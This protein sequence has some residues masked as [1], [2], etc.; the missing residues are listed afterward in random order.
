MVATFC[1]HFVNSGMQ[2]GRHRALMSPKNVFSLRRLLLFSAP[3]RYAWLISSKSALSLTK[4]L[5]NWKLT[6]QG[7][8]RAL[9][10]EQILEPAVASSLL[11]WWWCIV[12]TRANI[13]T[14]TKVFFVLPFQR[15]IF[16]MFT[17]AF[18]YCPPSK[19]P[20][21]DWPAQEPTDPWH[22]TLFLN[23]S[24]YSCFEIVLKCVNGVTSCACRVPPEAPFGFKISGS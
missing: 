24:T 10:T 5:K 6:L 18:T 19:Q 22:G 11:A 23:T 16:I 21:L 1:R 8:E 20:K 3:C 2:A 9:S 13:W 7:S 15:I 17:Y 12:C 14:E 4:I